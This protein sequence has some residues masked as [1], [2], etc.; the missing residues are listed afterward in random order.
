V[1][2]IVSSSYVGV[3]VAVYINPELRDLQNSEYQ[4]RNVGFQV[5]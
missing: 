3:Y 4:Y 2:V 1:T 5:P